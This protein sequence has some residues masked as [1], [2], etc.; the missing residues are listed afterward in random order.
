MRALFDT[1][2]PKILDL[3]KKTLAKNVIDRPPTI[4]MERYIEG[5]ASPDARD[6]VR[7]LLSGRQWTYVPFDTFMKRLDKLAR[8]VFDAIER[9]GHVCFVIDELHKSSFWVLALML[10]LQAKRADGMFE[11]DALSLAIDDN[12]SAGGL[13]SAFHLLPRSATLVYVDDAAYSGEQLSY[14][15]N[16]SVQQ[17]RYVNGF[18]PRSV[19]VAVPYMASASMRMFRIRDYAGLSLMHEVSFQSLLYRRPLAAVLCLDLFL[20]VRH[21]LFTEYKSFVF[22]VLGIQPPNTLLFFEHKIADSLSIPERWL[23]LGPCMPQNCKHA[24][25]VKSSM[26][27]ELVH[28]IRVEL[29]NRQQQSGVEL[30]GQTYKDSVRRVLD[31]MQSKRFRA[32]FLDKIALPRQA[33]KFSPLLPPEHCEPRYQQSIENY[34]QSH[35]SDAIDTVAPDAMGTF[36]CYR[37]PYKRES[38][39]HR[40]AHSLPP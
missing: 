24:W 25:R 19:I 5:Q 18:M 21:V 31:L 38:L 23:K 35:Q 34:I 28:M 11:R 13:Y 9:R 26:V 6:A 27:D 8:R 2:R 16:R 4:M 39:K 17:F 32:L 40:I 14:F 10:H 22:D 37:P 12:R 36:D 30:P 20:E 3:A 7:R 33:T 15:V 29:K 1:S